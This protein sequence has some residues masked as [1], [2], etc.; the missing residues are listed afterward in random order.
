MM[1]LVTKPGA[2]RAEQLAADLSR[3][4]IEGTLPPGVRLDE[5]SLAHRFGVSRTPVRE[6]LKRLAGLGLAE[7]R[8]HR[9]VIVVDMPAARV[10]E[11]FEALAEAEAVCA[12]LAAI[13]RSSLE[14]DQ[15]EA[16]HGEFE[17]LKS[18][19]SPLAIAI[20]NRAFHEGIYGGAH[21]GFLA[22]HV[23]SLRKRLAP[24]TTAQF[25]LMGRPLQ[26]AREHAIVL[27]SIRGRDGVTAGEVMRRHVMAVGAAWAQWAAAD[28]DRNAT[29]AGPAKRQSA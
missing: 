28:P 15:L 26:S 14:L 2:T 21:N 18:E 27:D 8:P 12:R 13:K 16:L 25:R 5:H 29:A 24:F 6:A 1:A 23:M 3:E 17:A 9:G 22:D 4:I 7:V 10:T 20:V 11:L 19:G